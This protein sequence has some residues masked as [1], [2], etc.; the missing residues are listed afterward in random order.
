M[1]YNIQ[2]RKISRA[3]VPDN[4]IFCVLQNAFI[5][6]SSVNTSQTLIYFI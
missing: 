2:I 1:I 5:A 4:G 6:E 3:Y